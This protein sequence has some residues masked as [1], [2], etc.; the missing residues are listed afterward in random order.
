MKSWYDIYKDRMN[1][2]YSSHVKKKY[3]PFI[4]AIHDTMRPLHN[5][6]Y[7]ELGCGAGNITRA[8]RELEPDSYFSLVDNCPKMLSLAIENNQSPNCQFSCAD[9]SKYSH[10]SWDVNHSVVHSH[11]VL[12]H[13]SDEDIRSIITLA[14]STSHHQVHYVPGAKYEKPSRGDERL[15]TVDQWSKILSTVD[16]PLKFE[17]EEFNSGYDFIIKLTRR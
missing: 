5:V 12:E 9:V 1:D 17:I 10:V 3:A 8:L 14:D 6:E 15:L 4:K 11:G 7:V 13:F 2:H 16:R